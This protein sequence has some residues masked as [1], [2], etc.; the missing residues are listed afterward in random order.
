MSIIL[1]NAPQVFASRSPAGHACSSAFRVLGLEVQMAQRWRF[2]EL[3]G[4]QVA[5]TWWDA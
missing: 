5:M 3:E 1:P 4:S 2:G